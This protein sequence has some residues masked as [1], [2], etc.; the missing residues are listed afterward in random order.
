M[1]GRERGVLYYK[2]ASGVFPFREWRSRISDD[3]TRAAIDAR[4]ARFRGGNLGNSEPVGGGVS[5]NK[6]FFGPGYRIYY[7]ID[8]GQVVLLC[9]GDKS[10]HSPDIK[11]AIAYWEDYK[12]REKERNSGEKKT[13]SAK[14]QGRSPGRSKK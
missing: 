1:E 13:G 3:D 12:R 4:I 2:T 6:I 5:E 9:A 11:R 10:T 14:L 8:E 7:A